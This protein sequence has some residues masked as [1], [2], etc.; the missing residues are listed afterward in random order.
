MA[1]TS[2]PAKTEIDASRYRCISACGGDEDTEDTEREFCYNV[3]MPG[4]KS[5]VYISYKRNDINIDSLENSLLE[6][7]FWD[8]WERL[9]TVLAKQLPP[10][11]E[12]R[13]DIYGFQLV[14]SSFIPC[15]P[16]RCNIKGPHNYPSF[17]E[18][19]LEHIQDL[20]H[21]MCNVSLVSAGANQEHMAFKTT[22]WEP[23]IG[24]LSDE[25]SNY[26]LLRDFPSIPRIL[27]LVFIGDCPTG[28]LMEPFTKGDLTKHYD[29]SVR[30]K[31]KWAWQLLLI[32]CQFEEREFDHKDL[33]CGNIVLDDDG[34]IKVID[35]ANCGWTDGFST[36]QLDGCQVF[37]MGRTVLE[38]FTKNVPKVRE[39][40]MLVQEEIKEQFEGLIGEMIWMCCKSI[41][42]KDIP[43]AR[44]VK[45]YLLPFA[46]KENLLDQ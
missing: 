12:D 20:G 10:L 38:L 32:V 27:G 9:P 45:E 5:R 1:E 41:T 13:L 26:D 35:P 28:F 19:D 2:A 8:T 23:E 43:S 24:I 44:E 40:P 34:N 4:G 29:A 14:N 11:P 30:E 31:T 46:A 7:D 22:H 33:K 18:H 42:P 39:V 16:P 36:P 37:S 25:L 21:G 6:E 17:Q 15:E 3:Q